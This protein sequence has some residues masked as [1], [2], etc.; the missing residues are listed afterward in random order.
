MIGLDPAALGEE[1]TAAHIVVV[2]AMLGVQR[3]VPHLSEASGEVVYAMGRAWGALNKA[4]Q[5]LEEWERQID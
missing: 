2:N 1:L 4:L 3:T 5:A